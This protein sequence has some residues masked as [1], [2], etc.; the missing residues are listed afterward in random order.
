MKNRNIKINPEVGYGEGLVMSNGA[1]QNLEGRVLTIIESLGL[2]VK[3]ED[4]VKSL[5]R[6]SLWNWH[7]EWTTWITPEEHTNLREKIVGRESN[8]PCSTPKYK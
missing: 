8:M 3:Q 5:F 1:V 2:A 6:D 4:A 7:Y